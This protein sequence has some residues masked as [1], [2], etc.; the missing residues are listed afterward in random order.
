MQQSSCNVTVIFEWATEN[1]FYLILYFLGVMIDDR[2]TFNA[3]VLYIKGKVGIGILNRCKRN[4]NYSTLLTWYYSFIYPYLNYC[5]CIW[6]NTHSSYL[7]PLQ[8]MQKI[9]SR[10]IAG[11]DRRTHT[12]PIF[13]EYSV[14][15]LKVIH[16]LYS[17]IF[18]QMPSQNC[19]R[20]IR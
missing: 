15:Y 13:R 16:L 8:K 5:N 19:A 14:Q 4:F 17:V 20:H 9:A 11:V 10:I 3:H 18:V 12:G 1:K 2:L 7:Y 6:G